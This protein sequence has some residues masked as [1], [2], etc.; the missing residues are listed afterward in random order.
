MPRR[1]LCLLGVAVLLCGCSSD[2]RA[3]ITG[4]VYLDGKPLETG[5]I[6]F[7]PEAG[8]ASPNAGAT[9]EDGYYE[10]PRAKGPFAG[11]YRV[12]IHAFRKT[13][14][15]I[16]IAA[17]VSL[18]GSGAMGDEEKEAIPPRYNSN[19]TLREELHAGENVFDFKLESK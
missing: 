4:T 17:P 16:P 10:V 8:T 11:S 3:G 2:R 5:F 19:T 18:G 12:E 7:Q 1:S 6:L 9:I 13:G 15:K 14:R